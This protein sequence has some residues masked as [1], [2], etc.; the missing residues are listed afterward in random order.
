MLSMLGI[1]KVLVGKN[2]VRNYRGARVKRTIVTAIKQAA[3]VVDDFLRKKYLYW[4]EGLSLCHSV[5]KGVVSMERLW[6]LVQVC[7][8]RSTCF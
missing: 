1:V 8:T 5:E 7:R 4:L 6:S 2:D 3:E